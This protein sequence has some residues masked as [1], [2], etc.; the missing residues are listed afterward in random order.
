MNDVLLLILRR[1]RVPILCL[2]VV[3]G[4]SVGGLTL[5][6]GVDPDGHPHKLSI[7]TRSTS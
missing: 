6:P 1:L 4:V 7:F 2:I 3:Y 5:M